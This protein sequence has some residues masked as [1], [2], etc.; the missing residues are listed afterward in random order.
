MT[1]DAYH[2]TAPHP[3]GAGALRAMQDA[4]KDAGVE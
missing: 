4:L 3:E 2:M 1:A